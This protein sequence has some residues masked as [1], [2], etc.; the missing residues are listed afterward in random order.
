M[1][2]NQELIDR[3]FQSKVTKK[4]WRNKHESTEW[5]EANAVNKALF[6]DTFSRS[7]NCGCIDDFFYLLELKLSKQSINQVMD[8]QFVLKK[9]KLIMSFG[10]DMVTENSTD[11]QCI[12]LLKL[13]K[14]HASKFAKL[15]ENWEEIVDNYTPKKADKLN[16][17]EKPV[18]EKKTRAKRTVKVVEEPK[19]DVEETE[20]EEIDNTETND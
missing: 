8:K 20:T 4:Q 2:I 3:V 13:N 9:G 17:V 11:D 7:T 5:L 15:P 18:K 16:D 14:K 6:Q 19:E 12:A 10:A 1:N